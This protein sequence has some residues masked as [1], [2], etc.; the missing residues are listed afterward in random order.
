MNAELSEESLR[1]AVFKFYYTDGIPDEID[2]LF[3]WA[4]K[5]HWTAIPRPIVTATDFQQR[6]RIIQR[7]YALHYASREGHQAA[8]NGQS[9]LL[10]V[11]LV[12][13]FMLVPLR[14][15]RSLTQRPGQYFPSPLTLNTYLS[16]DGET[17]SPADVDGETAPPTD[18]DGESEISVDS[19][20]SNKEEVD[21]VLDREEEMCILTGA[22]C[23]KVSYI[24]PYLVSPGEENMSRE[25][26]AQLDTI[27]FSLSQLSLNDL[28][29]P[30]SY[31]K[32]WNMIC[33]DRVYYY[34]WGECLFGLKCV[35]IRDVQGSDQCIIQLQFQWMHKNSL[36]PT[37]EMGLSTANAWQM[38]LDTPFRLREGPPTEDSVPLIESGQMFYITMPC[39]DVDKMKAMFDIRWANTKLAALSGATGSRGELQLPPS[40]PDLGSALTTEDVNAWL[41]DLPDDTGEYESDW[42]SGVQLQVPIGPATTQESDNPPSG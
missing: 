20:Y 32:S 35:G 16:L 9:P 5:S 26:I 11:P 38:L 12:S 24:V 29:A 19:L 14:H 21:K 18:V 40:E 30:E 42:E 3:D 36:S 8:S 1:R 17:A 22:P 7:I 6:M 25:F 31:N 34:W 27:M 33:M 13:Y 10:P 37:A 2:S 41:G 4:A 15:L 28:T 23:S 39:E